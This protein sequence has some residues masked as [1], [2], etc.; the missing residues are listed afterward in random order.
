[1]IMRARIFIQLIGLL[2]RCSHSS[3]I[4]S[5]ASTHLTATVDADEAIDKLVFVFSENLKA[6][7]VV[8]TVNP[9]ATTSAVTA[10][11]KTITWSCVF[12]YVL[13]FLGW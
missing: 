6:T 2:K 10:A 7:A 9:T 3:P 11:T 5:V 13:Y 1:M 12:H 8:A 4:A